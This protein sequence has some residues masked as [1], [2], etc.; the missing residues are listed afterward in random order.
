MKHL[1]FIAVVTLGMIC[2][3]CAHS[4]FG[5][6]VGSDRDEHGCIGSAGYTWSY[7]LHSCVRLWEVGT[8]FDNGPESVFLI[9]SP[10]STFAEIFPQSSSSVL[11]KR[12]KNTNVWRPKK[13]NEEVS[14]VNGVT[15]VKVND[16]SYTRSKDWRWEL[17]FISLLSIRFQNFWF[18]FH[19]S[20]LVSCFTFQNTEGARYRSLSVFESLPQC[21]CFSPTVF[22]FFSLSVFW[23]KHWNKKWNIKVVC[24]SFQKHW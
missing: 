7:A 12:V 1:I 10:D 2:T 3:S 15:C 16:F 9:Y 21:F 5:K 24:F 22:L 13:G 8:R 6:L 11:C 23:M 20:F 19:V 14:I 18:I 17:Q 4:S